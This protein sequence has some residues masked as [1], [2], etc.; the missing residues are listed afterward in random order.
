MDGF[1]YLHTNGD[2]IF[3]RFEPE[4]DSP[5]VKKVWS[6]DLT[7]RMNAWTIAL[8]GLFLGAKTERI[9]DLANKWG[10]TLNDSIEMLTRRKGPSSEE[11]GGLKLFIKEILKMGE[12]E[13]WE[14]AKQEFKEKKEVSDGIRF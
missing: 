8:E 11:V 12:E 14:K 3:K 4:G 2:M 1:Y 7:N 9:E 10:L 5:F 13:F 6:L